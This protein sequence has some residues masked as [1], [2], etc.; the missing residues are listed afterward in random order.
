MSRDESLHRV[1]RGHSLEL[2]QDERYDRSALILLENI[3]TFP[4]GA[5]WCYWIF[6]SRIKP[7]EMQENEGGEEKGMQKGERM[8]TGW[9]YLECMGVCVGGEGRGGFRIHEG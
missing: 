7:K 1:E 9:V 6:R 2:P 8:Q 4:A 5:F 3:S